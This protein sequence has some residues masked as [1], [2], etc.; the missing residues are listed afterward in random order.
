MDDARQRH[1]RWALERIADIHRLAQ[2]RPG[3][4]WR[5][6]RDRLRRGRPHG[7]GEPNCNNA[8]PKG[9]EEAGQIPAVGGFCWQQTGIPRF[10]GD[11]SLN[12]DPTREGVE[13]DIAFTGKEDS[14]PWVVWYEK[15]NSTIGL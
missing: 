3:P 14:V 6:P 7:P 10:G 13:P 2:L 1:A 15:A 11:P 8:T 9:V 12:V 4:G 5:G